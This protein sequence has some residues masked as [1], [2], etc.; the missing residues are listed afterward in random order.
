MRDRAPSGAD[1]GEG[2]DAVFSSTP[3]R[4]SLCLLYKMLFFVGEGCRARQK[5]HFVPGRACNKQGA[6]AR[7]CTTRA[8]R[9]F[10]RVPGRPRHRPPRAP[11]AAGECGRPGRAGGAVARTARRRAE[12]ERCPPGRASGAKRARAT[13]EP[14]GARTV[15]AVG[16]RERVQ[17]WG[18][19]FLYNFC[20]RRSGLS[21]FSGGGVEIVEKSVDNRVDPWYNADS[22]IG[23]RNSDQHAV[24]PTAPGDLLVSGFVGCVRAPRTSSKEGVFLVL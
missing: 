18:G 11:C 23:G 12:R 22:V 8:A 17:G 9:R 1:P 13:W 24:S 2:V 4:R 5:S 3:P 6:V 16:E 7:G 14:T 20:I 19:G 10:E 15:R 21:V